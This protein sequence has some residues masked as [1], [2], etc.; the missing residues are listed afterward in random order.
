MRPW[1]YQVLPALLRMRRRPEGRQ[2]V[3]AEF[4]LDRKVAGRYRIH[5]RGHGEITLMCPALDTCSDPIAPKIRT[6]KS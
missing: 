4:R 2:G 3:T 5:V 6:L 1:P